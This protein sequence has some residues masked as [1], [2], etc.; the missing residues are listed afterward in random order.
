[1]VAAIQTRDWPLFL[2]PV[3]REPCLMTGLLLSTR[4]E[5]G[6]KK[7]GSRGDLV[8]GGMEMSHGSGGHGFSQP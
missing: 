6:N 5:D 3:P 2:E 4:A 1:M 7:E 8:V